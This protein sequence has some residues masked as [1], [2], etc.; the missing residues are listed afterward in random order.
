MKVSHIVSYLGALAGSLS[1]IT[2]SAQAASFTPFLFQTHWSGNPPQGDV[3]LNAVTI[4]GKTVSDFATVT[5]ASI[6]YNPPYTGGNSGAASS[7]HGDQTT[8]QALAPEGPMVEDPTDADVVASLGNLNLN[9]IIDTEDKGTATLKVG[10]GQAQNHF[11]FWERGLNSDLQVE[12]LDDAGTVLASFT[13]TRDL[14]ENAGFQIN[15]TEIANTQSVGALGL[16]LDGAGASW[17]QLSSNA[18]SKG[19]DYKVVAAQVP[20]PATVIGLGIVA[21]ALTLTRRRQ[22]P[23]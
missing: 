9:S 6:L 2:G 17:L 8:L 18:T 22:C 12:A 21:G 13:I 20:E 15:T 23:Q 11:L 16:K 3:L 10:F 7:D 4:D 19:P 5:D 1:T 14:W